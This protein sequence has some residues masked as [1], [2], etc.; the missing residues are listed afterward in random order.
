MKYLLIMVFGVFFLLPNK[1]MGQFNCPP[2][3]T[4]L[5]PWIDK[6]LDHRLTDKNTV[7]IEAHI[8]YRE[9]CDGVLEFVIDSTIAK[10][11]AVYLEDFQFEEYE[12]NTA[13]DLIW[14]H[15]LEYPNDFGFS[16]VPLCSNDTLKMAHV[17]TA[18]CGVWLKCSY[19]VDPASQMCDIGYIPP[20]PLYSH[21]GFNW[22]NH[23]KWHSCGK[24]CCRKEYRICRTTIPSRPGYIYKVIEVKKEKILDCEKE[25]QFFDWRT[26][27]TIPCNDDC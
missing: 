25:G 7:R 12:V 10:K 16:S 11:N 24:A 19:K 23:W 8:R 14:L 17:Y 6:M 20:Y 1:T 2:Q 9:N 21:G 18:S 15:I 27:Q 13:R 3:D 22:V 26:Q 5:T 4:C